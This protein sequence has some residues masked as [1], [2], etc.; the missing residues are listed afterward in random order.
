PLN[1]ATA[2]PIPTQA[3]APRSVAKISAGGV[4]QTETFTTTGTNSISGTANFNGVFSPD[5]NQFYVTNSFTI[6]YFSAFTQTANQVAGTAPTGTVPTPPGPLTL[7]TNPIGLQNAGGNLAVVGQVY[8][9]PSS[10]SLVGMYTGMPTA[11]TANLTVSS[12]TEIGT[13][14][15]AT[16]S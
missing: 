13:T 15:T 9:S 3:S 10:A 14:V 7:N 8:G 2:A 16:T 5:G 6:F 4:V 1:A 11:S 12:L